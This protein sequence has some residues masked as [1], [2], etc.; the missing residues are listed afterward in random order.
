MDLQGDPIQT[1]KSL[2]RR[3]RKFVSRRPRAR[4]PEAA[5]ATEIQEIAARLVKPVAMS[6]VSLMLIKT[7]GTL[8]GIHSPKIVSGLIREGLRRSL[9]TAKFK[10]VHLEIRADEGL[11]RLARSRHGARLMAVSHQAG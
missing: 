1:G 10:Q 6:K 4:V 9:R 3:I 7:G 5:R 11:A 2:V 8:V